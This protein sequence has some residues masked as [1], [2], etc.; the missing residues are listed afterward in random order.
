MKKRPEHFYRFAE[1]STVGKQLHDFFAE[2]ADA[3]EQARVWAEKQGA[4]SYYESPD[5]MA[6]GVGLV[7]FEN[8]LS[9]E[10]WESMTTPDGSLLFYPAPDSALEKEMYALPVVSEMKLIPILS[11]K[12]RKT[13]DE[14]PVP[15]TFGNETPVLFLH[16]GYWYA[17]VP[18]ESE[19]E[20]AESIMERE[21]YKRKMAATNER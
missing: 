20:C 17:K 4:K 14:K 21:F 13:K 3:Q 6:G 15:F 11:F 2:C 16:Y 19:A 18:Y 9:K 7:E 12:P 8:C 1:D 10:G 5:G